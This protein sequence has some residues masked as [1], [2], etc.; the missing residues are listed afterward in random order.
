MNN[1][2]KQEKKKKSKVHGKCYLL[3]FLPVP[4]D[5]NKNLFVISEMFPHCS[6]KN[7]LHNELYIH[8]QRVHEL[9][10]PL[11]QTC[12]FSTFQRPNSIRI[13]FLQ[14]QCVCGRT[15]DII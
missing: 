14:L 11:T 12:Q 6:L 4:R 2:D 15:A 3:I 13:I 5:L 8:K 10:L 1:A 7:P 9:V